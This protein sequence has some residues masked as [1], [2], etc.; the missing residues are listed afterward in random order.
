MYYL[1]LFGNS[2]IDRIYE[3]LELRVRIRVETTNFDDRRIGIFIVIDKPRG[4]NVQE[5]Y[6]VVT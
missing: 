1:R 5:N 4:F 3:T 6:F 2:D